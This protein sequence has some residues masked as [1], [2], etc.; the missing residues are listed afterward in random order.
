MVVPDE[1]LRGVAEAEAGGE[2]GDEGV[3]VVASLRGGPG[4]G[5][6]VEAAGRSQR[7]GPE[8][9]VGTGAEAAGGEREE[10][11][12]GGR[13]RRVVQAGREALGEAAVGLQEDLGGGAQPGG[14][15]QS[16]DAAEPG[17]GGE[18][19]GEGGQP[20]RVG[21]DVVVGEGDDGP[22]GGGEPGVVGDGE[23]G[24]V[25]PDVP[26]AAGVPAGHERVGGG[27][28]GRVVDDDQLV[29][30]VVLGEERVEG[31][32]E[33]LGA[34]TGGDDDGGAGRGA[35]GGLRDRKSVV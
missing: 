18:G 21:D 2:D 25:L 35:R 34:L 20:V 5:R 17:V 22:F 8:G 27:G 6:R 33:G 1:G 10:R 31:A 7:P 3:Q 23:A 13:P 26:D 19:R 16:G 11:F 30:R 24:G 4:A 12:V 32:G 14:Q 15:D 9:H 28:A 29:V